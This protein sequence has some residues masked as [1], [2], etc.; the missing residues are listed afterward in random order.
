MRKTVFGDLRQQP[1]EIYRVQT[2]SSVYVVSLHEERGRRY[3]LVRGQEGSDREHVVVRD[4]DPRIGER[5]L[6]EVPVAEW[7]GHSLDVATMRTSPIVSAARLGPGVAV[8]PEPVGVGL[9]PPPGM[10]DRPRIVPV[11]SRGTHVGAS[12]PAQELARQVVVQDQPNAVPYPLR[13]VLYAENI[14]ALLRSIHRRDRLVA[15]IGPDRGLRERLAK[16]LAD[17]E[18][19]IAEIRRRDR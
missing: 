1:L 5:S 11:A 19:L 15:D 18:Q 16:A 17:A 7:V 14:V 9:P 8:F 3:A 2:E 6:F 12:M 4:S 13:H 10:S